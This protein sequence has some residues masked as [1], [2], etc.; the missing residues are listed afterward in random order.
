MVLQ[1]LPLL[2]HHKAEQSHQLRLLIL[3]FQIKERE[4]IV[5]EIRGLY[6]E[7]QESSRGWHSPLTPA[8]E[9]VLLMPVIKCSEVKECVKKSSN[10]CSEDDNLADLGTEQI[11]EVWCALL[12]LLFEG[13][14]DSWILW[15]SIA[16]FWDKS[17]VVAR[18]DGDTNL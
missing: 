8:P 16:Q 1:C 18:I 10:I 5:L 13:K 12:I 7:G 17:A 6:V 4:W 11:L 3:F 14:K 9:G 2:K 15:Y